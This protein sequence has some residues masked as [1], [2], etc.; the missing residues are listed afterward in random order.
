MFRG[1]LIAVAIAATSIAQTI[2]LQSV[3]ARMTVTVEAARGKEVGELNRQDVLVFHNKQRLTVTD[4]TALK[5][6]HASLELFLLLDDASGMSLGSQLGD[7]RDFINSQPAATQIGIAYMQNG[8]AKIV[9]NLT[10]D[11]ARAAE[12]LR[13][14]FG[15]IAAGTSPYLALDDLIKKWPASN[16]RREVVMISSGVDPLGGPSPLNPF[17]DMVIE[18]AQLSGFIVY[19]MYAPQAGHAG[20]S[21]GIANSGQNHLAQLAE[22]T[23]GESYM[24]GFGAPVSFEPYLRDLAEHLA[25]QYSIEFQVPASSQPELLSV[26]IESEVPGIEIIAAPRVFVWPLKPMSE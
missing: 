17:L 4:W 20:H 6:E 25:H 22:A 23:G 11:H 14:P 19:T 8:G 7:L 18:H 26:K 2:P 10:A 21:F 15:A 24:L 16:V 5:N 13:L 9:Q 3:P 1:I 12:A